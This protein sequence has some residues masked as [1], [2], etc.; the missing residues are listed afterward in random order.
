MSILSRLDCFSAL[1]KICA[2]GSLLLLCATAPADCVRTIDRVLLVSTRPAGC[3]TQA[4]QLA[5]KATGSE[6]LVECRCKPKWIK[7][8]AVEML[9]SLD[10]S[11]PTIM[12][13]HGNQVPACDAIDLGM[14]VYGRLVRCAEPSRPMQ[15]VIFSWCSSKV[16]GYLR[17]VRE[18]AARTKP[19][20]WQLAW[21]MNQVPS[22]GSIGLLGYSY[23]ARISS[24]ATHLLAGGTLGSLSIGDTAPSRPIRVVY[25]AAAMD[26]CWL[27]TK[28]Y[29]RHAIDRVDSALIT[30][31]QVDPAM[32]FFRFSSKSYNP[33]AL[34]YCGP[35]GLSSSNRCKVRLSNV[36]SSVGRTHLLQEYIKAPG[37]MHS[38]WRRLAFVDHAPECAEPRLAER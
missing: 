36:T 37:L 20:A 3:S 19:V 38:A 4:H 18:K 33:K 17:D 27:S 12:F 31:N 30:T 5:N 2:I 26:A 29:H 25:L 13:V 22:G 21:A 34:G 9:S 28:G 7:G 11:V 15:F 16:R 23:G 24:G 6:R 14:Q 35:I 32:K 10:P 8:S 1:H